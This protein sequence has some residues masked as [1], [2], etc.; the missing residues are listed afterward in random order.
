MVIAT[1]CPTRSVP[2]LRVG[3]AIEFRNPDGTTFQSKVAAV[4]FADPYDPNRPF[5]FPIPPSGSAKEKIQIS[6]E[7]WMISDVEQPLI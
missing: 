2:R 4:E 5:V 6:A 1:D 7:I 3:D